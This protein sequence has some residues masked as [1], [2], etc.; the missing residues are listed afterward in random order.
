MSSPVSWYNTPWFQ[1][2]ETWE[3][4]GDNPW[5]LAVIRRDVARETIN[6]GWTVIWPGTEVFVLRET[7]DDES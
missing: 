4:Q 3:V 1:T 7:P 5:V 2:N 6:L